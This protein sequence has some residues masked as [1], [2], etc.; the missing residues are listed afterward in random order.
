MINECVSNNWKVLLC[1]RHKSV[2]NSLA[3]TG[4]TSHKC[5][6]EQAHITS[7]MFVCAL[8]AH[9]ASPYGDYSTSYVYSVLSCPVRR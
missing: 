6:P 3:I 1:F 5:G 8:S 9:C 4:K 7:V 2:M